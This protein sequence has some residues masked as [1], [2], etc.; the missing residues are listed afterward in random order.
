M[1]KVT[2]YFNFVAQVGVGIKASGSL[3]RGSVFYK[4]FIKL[5]MTLGEWR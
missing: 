5:K 1:Q 2:D 3:T 4:K